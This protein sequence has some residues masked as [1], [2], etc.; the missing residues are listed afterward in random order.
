MANG[1]ELKTIYLEHFWINEAKT[2]VFYFLRRNTRLEF[3]C[4][5]VYF[6]DKSA[7]LSWSIHF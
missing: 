1:A 6:F 3:P 4:K 2:S 5:K 7:D